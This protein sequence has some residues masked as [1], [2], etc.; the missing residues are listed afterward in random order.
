MAFSILVPLVLWLFE[1]AESR[2]EITFRIDEKVGARP[3]R[4]SIPQ[5]I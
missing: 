1:T 5:T 2:F 3:Y 4:L